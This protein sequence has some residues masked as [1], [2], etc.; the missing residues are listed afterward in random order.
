MIASVFVG[1]SVDGFIARLN[2]EFD[3]LPE[4]GGEPHGYDDTA[5][6]ERLGAER[7]SRGT[8]RT[9]CSLSFRLPLQENEPCSDTKNSLVSARVAQASYR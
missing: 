5:L 6:S 7:V 3:F 8:V 2:G 1:A 4:G 9:R